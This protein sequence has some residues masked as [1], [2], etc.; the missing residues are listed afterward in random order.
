MSKPHYEG[1]HFSCKNLKP[2]EHS[3]RR[4][5]NEDSTELVDCIKPCYV[6]LDVIHVKQNYKIRCLIHNMYNCKCININKRYANS[7]F[8]RGCTVETKQ[9]KNKKK[10]YTYL[11]IKNILQQKQQKKIKH[12]T[13]VEESNNVD[14]SMHTDGTT[15]IVQEVSNASFS[16]KLNSCNSNSNKISKPEEDCGFTYQ[17][18]E[19]ALA[20]DANGG[21]VENDYLY[22]EEDNVCKL[23]NS[24]ILFFDCKD[25]DYHLV[26]SEK[27]LDSDVSNSSEIYSETGLSRSVNIE[28][29]CVNLDNYNKKPSVCIAKKININVKDEESIENTLVGLYENIQN[30][31][32]K[33]KEE[34][35]S[36]EE[37]SVIN[38]SIIELHQVN[39]IEEQT[40][41]STNSTQVLDESKIGILILHKP[42]ENN[43]R[44]RSNELPNNS[45]VHDVI[46]HK[47][48]KVSNLFSYNVCS[49]CLE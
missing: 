46:S 7:I 48:L 29:T 11:K 43:F 21:T 32:P 27:N 39:K 41:I 40:A 25:S 24:E 38:E 8:C 36:D 9:V 6:K 30:V 3:E 18:D 31:I 13:Y 5:F 12:L 49:S 4:L 42:I 19:V 35:V 37:V 14:T 2:M 17:C 23:N 47:P 44:E 1:V 28:N 33:I 15:N 22:E 45:N 16:K 20:F 10:H 26:K 34:V